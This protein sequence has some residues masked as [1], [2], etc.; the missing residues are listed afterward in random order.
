MK[1]ILGLILAFTLSFSSCKDYLTIVPSDAMFLGDV[2]ALKQTLAAWLYNYRNN[3]KY[4]NSAGPWPWFPTATSN[5]YNAY[6]DVS[7]FYPWAGKES[8]TDA[9]KRYVARADLNA[10]EWSRHYAIIGLMN[11]IL[12]E[13]DAAKGDGD[14]RNYVKG[15][16][17]IHRAFSFFKLLQCYAPMNDASLGV[18]IYLDT[19]GGFDDADLSRK[20][21]KAVF[22]R[23]LADLA[24]AERLLGI[25]ET[26][27]AYNVMYNYDHVYRIMSQVYLWK[28]S[29]PVA[30]DGDWK[31]AA[32]AAKKAIEVAGNILPWD[33]AT[34]ASTKFY[35]NGASMTFPTS[36]YPEA[37]LYSVE[38]IIQ[39]NYG[40]HLDTWKTLYNKNDERKYRWFGVTTGKDPDLVTESELNPTKKIPGF[41]FK[42][43]AAY[44]RL[45]EQYLILIEACAHTDFEEGK[46]VLR[47]W[48]SVRYK[49]GT[50]AEWFVP[51]NADALLEEVYRERKREFILEGDML[52]FDM[53]RL[54]ATDS[55]RSIAGFTAEPLKADDFRYNFMIP[56]SETDTNPDIK[57]NPG[58]EE[59]Q[60]I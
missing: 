53:K 1:K 34:L 45:S 29:G 6:S 9:E 22:D 4:V 20:S 14:M 51:S 50:E 19:Y 26:R 8:L 52:W 49:T 33:I 44:F 35:G 32:S 15:E 58:W 3:G 37:L 28:A 7:G 54:G 59:Y 39:S 21:Q 18:P 5:K 17:L 48:Q 2:Q 57:R 31:N 27:P 46:K 41:F 47:Q 42:K 25:T 11:L 60:T 13:I 40:Y 12:N 43:V 24:E 56:S 55:G 23:I 38:L 16:A 36:A 30:E 10:D